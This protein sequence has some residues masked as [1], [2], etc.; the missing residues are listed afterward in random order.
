LEEVGVLVHE[1]DFLKFLARNGVNVDFDEK[2]A[3]M[4]PSLI[5][6]CIKK[7]PKHVTLYAREPKYNISLDEGKMFF[8]I[9][10]LG[11]RT[12]VRIRLI[13]HLLFQM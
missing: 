9:F 1:N 13:A 11:Q 10:V 2:R 3:K 4:P 6:E 8:Q 12:R 5:E 7:T